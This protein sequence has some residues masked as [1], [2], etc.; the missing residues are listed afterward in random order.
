MNKALKIFF[1]FLVFLTVCYYIAKFTGIAALYHIPTTAN[2]PNLKSGTYIIVSNRITPTRGDFITYEFNQPEFGNSDFMHRLC[3]V[4]NDTIEIINGTLF[5][6]GENF[7]ENYNLQH[8]YLL[9]K[10]KFEAMNNDDI[11]RI[12]IATKEGNTAYLAFVQDVDAQTYKLAKQRYR[13]LKTIPDQSIIAQ[14]GKDW[15]KDHF[16][17]LVIPEGKVFVLGDNRDNSQDSRFSGLINAKAIKGVLW[18]KLFTI[19]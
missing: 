15:N 10:P 16:G 2:E 6:N 1:Y 19:N 8:A 13:D 17:P 12:P 9:S 3:G 7:D 5:V 11:E 14:Y 18:K 4:E